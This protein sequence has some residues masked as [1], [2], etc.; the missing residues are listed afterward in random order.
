MISIIL[1]YYM[2]PYY[3]IIQLTIPGDGIVKISLVTITGATVVP[4]EK[5]MD[6]FVTNMLL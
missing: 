5:K 2:I 6:I 3:I 4:T 1:P